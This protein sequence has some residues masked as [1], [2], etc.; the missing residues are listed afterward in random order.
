MKTTELETAVLRA[1]LADADLEK[2]RST[3]N[4]DKVT[5]CDRELT[6]VGFLTE[7]ERSDEL[8][9]FDSGFSSR[10][11]KIGAR[12]NSSEIETGYLVYIDD[13]YV[14]TLEGYTY[15]DEWP[16]H[17]D[18]IELYELKPGMKLKT[19]PRN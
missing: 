13:G 4:F 12:L 16:E 6:G 11:G 19:P 2:I 18:R 15:G 14:T 17:I 8:K 5:V 9:L 7:L 3:V 1:M 10:W